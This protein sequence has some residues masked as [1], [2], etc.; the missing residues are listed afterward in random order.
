[1]NRRKSELPIF[2]SWIGMTDLRTM[3]KWR[4]LQGKEP[5][6]SYNNGKEDN[7]DNYSGIEKKGENGPVRTFTDGRK[8]DLI[9]LLATNKLYKDAP[10]FQKWVER[11]TDAEC[12][13]VYVDVKDPSDYSDVYFALKSFYDEYSIL[14]NSDRVEFHV[15]SGTPATQAMTVL[16]AHMMLPGSKT[17]KTVASKY[18]DPSTGSQVF[19]ITLPFTLTGKTLNKTDTGIVPEN[20]KIEEIAQIYAKFKNVSILLLGE[21]GVG[22]TAAA[23]KIHKLSGDKGKFVIAN[24]AELAHGDGNLFRS[25]L[26]GTK[27]GAYTGATS[28][29]KGLFEE[30][31]G[32]TIFLDEIGEV[33][34]SHQQTLLRVLNDRTAQRVGDS[35]SYRI[36]D[37]RIIAATNRDLAKDVTEGRFRED[38]YY[39][40]AMCPVHL[41]SLQKIKN[42]SME[43][44]N[45]IVASIL[46]E[47]Q[48]D[49]QFRG[50]KLSLTND[51][52]EYIRSQ[53]W[54]GNLRQ[55][56]HVLQVSAVYA[57]Y[58]KRGIIDTGVLKRHFFEEPARHGTQKSGAKGDEIPSNLDQWLLEQK[59]TFVERALK[60]CNYKILEAARMLG[61]SY[62]RVNTFIKSKDFKNRNKEE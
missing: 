38:L 62:Q 55:L 2:V 42:D 23:E 1:M 27:K 36:D 57:F 34:L 9:Y 33:P 18:A 53:R 50:T 22:K 17:F 49:E 30:A 51:G 61:M 4:I 32:G 13:I 41:E 26:F 39:R 5:A 8:A 40:I 59:I 16:T 14:E 46:N 21:T 43:K 20:Q 56:H 47:I 12:R 3:N 44:F 37:V 45:D 19:E 11:G 58:K 25:E 28:D 48:S 35:N 10:F 6:L 15:S 31:K 52:W 24:C 7:L 29:R 60:K 54:S